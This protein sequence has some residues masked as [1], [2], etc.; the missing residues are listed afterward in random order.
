MIY[1]PDTVKGFPEFFPPESQKFE[2][3][4]R[5]VEDA[6]TRYGFIPLKTPTIEFDELA[7]AENQG[8]EDEAVSDRF[9]L[10]DKGGRNLTLR[11]EF[12]YQLARVF[13]QHQD[14]KLPFR[15]YQIGSVFRD[16]PTATGRY[17]EFT[18]CDIDILGDSSI[19]ADAEC[20]AAAS[21]ILKALGIDANIQINNRKLMNAILDSVQIVQKKE[22]MRELDKL[23]K[24]GED[25]VKLNLK[26]YA[27]ANQIITLFKLL[28][29][30]LA[31]FM[32]N[33][34]DGAEELFKLKDLGK[35]Y[36]YTAKFNP[37]LMR[38]L[39][40]YT[41]NV[42]ECKVKESKHSI[43]GGGRYA[44]V[45]GKFIRREI[46]SVGISFSI[47][48][49]MDY[50]KIPIRKTKVIIISI[51]QPHATILLAQKLRREGIPA[52]ISFEKVGKALEYANAYDIPF[53]IFVG[54]DELKKKKFK[55][56]DLQSGVEKEI[57]ES[58]LFKQLR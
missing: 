3:I 37:F 21:D 4:K 43:A 27:D 28:E 33:L 34:F 32:K 5:I 26:K 54:K 30:D 48:R 40:Y 9:K 24:L 44:G 17:R 52:F 47:E 31:F 56:K 6:F 14:I 38:G 36:G 11:H 53:A 16:E 45:A 18:Q 46:P 51:E 15:R 57:S 19:E 7:R 41:G 8:T 29:K 1:E 50:A 22:V 39:S 23:D 55:L 13:K 49:L 12:T 25:T 2:A 58:T 42:F 20:L 35:W 10:Q